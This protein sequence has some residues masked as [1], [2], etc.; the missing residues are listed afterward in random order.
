MQL[1]FTANACSIYRNWPT[2]P[3][4]VIMSKLQFL[5]VSSIFCTERIAFKLCARKKKKNLSSRVTYVLVWPTVNSLC[6]SI[7]GNKSHSVYFDLMLS[8]GGSLVSECV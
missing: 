3:D 8:M 6:V 7:F 4:L 1:L 2:C 5:L